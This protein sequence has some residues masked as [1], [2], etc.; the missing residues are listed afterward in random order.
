MKRTRQPLK[1][2]P[3]MK[4][5]KTS[6]KAVIYRQPSN[7]NVR[8]V[9]RHA[10]L[11]V[12]S[13]NNVTGNWGAYTFRLNQ[14]AGYSELT[15]MYDRYKINAVEMIFYPRVSMIDSLATVDRPGP[16]RFLTAIDYT[17]A[18]PPTTFNEVREYE[19]CECTVI[20]EKHTRYIPYPKIVDS[21][22]STRSSYVS[23]GSPSTA[24]YGLKY[25]IEPTSSTG[26]GVMDYSVEAVFYMSF[27]DLK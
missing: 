26:T 10:D 5:Q 4:V 12:I 8:L 17:D 20:Y 27:K 23:T 13:V 16:A 21:S 14:V 6:K 3:A 15:A 25:A 24:H 9:K 19:T 1:K 7:A 18:T 22:S 2:T 11:G